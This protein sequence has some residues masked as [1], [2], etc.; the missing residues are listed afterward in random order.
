MVDITIKAHLILSPFWGA[1]CGLL[2]IFNVYVC[3][4]KCNKN[5]EYNLKK[6][7]LSEKLRERLQYDL[8]NAG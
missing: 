2:L 4:Y 1:D 8:L 5:T 3:V 7:N 6:K